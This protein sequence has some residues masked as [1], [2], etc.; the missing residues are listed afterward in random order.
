MFSENLKVV[1]RIQNKNMVFLVYDGTYTGKDITY[2][3]TLCVA[4]HFLECLWN[5][6]LQKPVQ[7]SSKVWVISGDWGNMPS[8]L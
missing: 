7:Q 8:P 5:V 1:Y 3:T 4:K 2:E 6:V